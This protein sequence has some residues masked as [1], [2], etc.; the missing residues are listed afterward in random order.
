MGGVIYTLHYKRRGVTTVQ[1]V[2]DIYGLSL[3]QDYAIVYPFVQKTINHKLISTKSIFINI[4]SNFY[5][6]IL[7]ENFIVSVARQLSEKYNYTIY[8]NGTI[9][10]AYQKSWYSTIKWNL[11]YLYNNANQFEAILSIRTGLL[12][13]IIN[14]N[15]KIFCF[16]DSSE[17]GKMLNRVFSLS[18]WKSNSFIEEIIVERQN[19]SR[20]VEYL[21]RTIEASKDNG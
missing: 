7:I 4:N 17:K 8:F 5:K 11:P 9:N 14:T 13:F 19:V 6:S 3:D 21:I 16:Y 12:D 10:Y 1:R 20:F 2:K 15:S 18:D